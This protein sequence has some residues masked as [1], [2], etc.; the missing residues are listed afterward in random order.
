MPRRGKHKRLRGTY[1]RYAAL[2]WN[3]ASWS[4]YRFTSLRAARAYVTRHCATL[5]KYFRGETR[6]FNRKRFKLGDPWQQALAH[7]DEFLAMD[8]LIWGGTRGLESAVN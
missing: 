4:A 8:E 3:G 2:V 6:R 5:P 7:A 1:G